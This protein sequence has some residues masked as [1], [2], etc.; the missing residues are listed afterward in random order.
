MGAMVS[1][2]LDEWPYHIMNTRTPPQIARQAILAFRGVRYSSTNATPESSSINDQPP[3][4][5]TQEEPTNSEPLKPGQQIYV[6]YHLQK[7]N[8]VYSFERALHNAHA[9]SQ[10]SFNGK[11]TVPAAL[12][13]DLWH[14]LA[15]L[16]FPSSPEIGRSVFQ[17]LREYRRR[18]EQEWDPE[19]FVKKDDEGNHIPYRKQLR[20]LGDQKANSIADIAAVLRRLSS[21]FATESGEEEAKGKI[22][23]I[24]EGTGAKV[25][26]KWSEI[27]DNAFAEKWS[28]NVKHS[29]LEPYANNRDPEGT[30][31]YSKTQQQKRASEASIRA[32]KKRAKRVK[33][34]DVK[35]RSGIHATR[36]KALPRE[37]KMELREKVRLARERKK[38]P[39]YI[40][41]QET[42]VVE[43]YNV[44]QRIQRDPK[45][46][47]Y[48]QSLNPKRREEAIRARTKRRAKSLAKK[49]AREMREKMEKLRV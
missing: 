26:V 45:F 11:K 13:K 47:A 7:K 34:S 49:D 20:Q 44:K 37:E 21:S 5:P 3:K 2:D 40:N 6:F 14:P 4:N 9:L 18:H 10:I 17:K 35:T 48:W 39:E 12:R 28:E 38:E 29:V 42:V 23:L 32:E 1:K 33:Y 8:V 31:G 22:G 15:T 36:Y 24:G 16:T 46:A 19:D 30:R 27:Y 43:K 41:K 25:E